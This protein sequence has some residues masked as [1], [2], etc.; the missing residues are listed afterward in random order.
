MKEFDEKTTGAIKCGKSLVL[1]IVLPMDDCFFK[2]S[3]MVCSNLIV[4]GKITSLFDLVVLGSVQANEIDVKGRF[5]CLGECEVKASI[6]V[7]GEIWGNK[8]TSSSIV[9]HDRILAQELS[10]DRLS[11]EGNIVI[12][13]TLSMEDI[14]QTSQ[15]I[16]CGETV[17]GAGKIYANTLVTGEEIDLDD[18][19]DAVQSPHRIVT[20]PQPTAGESKIANYINNNDYS[21]YLTYLKS[22]SE[23]VIFANQIDQWLNTLQY[24]DYHSKNFFEGCNDISLLVSLTEITESEYFEGWSEILQW[25]TAFSQYFRL[26]ITGELV[27][28][29]HIEKKITDYVVDDIVKHNTLGKGIV[30]QIDKSVFCVR[31]DTKEND[32]KFSIEQSAKFFKY[33]GHLNEQAKQPNESIDLKVHSYNDWL[34]KMSIITKYK[35]CFYEE[36][37]DVLNEKLLADMGLKARFVQ[38]RIKDKGWSDVE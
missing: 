9:C 11:A 26:I 4:E 21:G 20:V 15:N 37:F 19:K 7:N 29:Q 18:G 8:I 5:I 34:N 16:V 14:V 38:D 30:T 24:V 25:H 2:C 32:M 10:V 27:P 1:P 12:G 3:Y 23:N 13:N 17:F 6:T 36:V 33:I 28:V 22:K 31:F 35:D